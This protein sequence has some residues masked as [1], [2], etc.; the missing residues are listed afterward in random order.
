[1]KTLF[2]VESPSKISSISK[3][4]GNDYIVC[5]TVG[6]MLDLT[7]KTLSVDTDTMKTTQAVI[8]GKAKQIAA[9]RK[10]F[11]SCDEVLLAGD[12]DRE[13]EAICHQI[14]TVLKVPVTSTKR[15][16]FNEITKPALITAL[17]N[18][19]TIDINLYDAQQTRRII[20]R[21]VGYK[22][23]PIVSRG[24]GFK[25]LSAGRVQSVVLKFICDR[26]AQIDN[27]SP[28]CSPNITGTFNKII[29]ARLPAKHCKTFEQAA[30]LMDKAK[31]STFR[32]EDLT[33]KE[34]MR[35]PPAPFI[36]STMQQK[37]Q[38]MCGFGV[39]RTMQLAQKLYM[40]GKITYL[41]TDKPVISAGFVPK[42]QAYIKKTFGAAYVA[43][44][45]R[46]AKKSKGSQEAHEAIRPTKI[47]DLGA[48]ISDPMQRKLYQLIWRQA[49]ASCASPAK[50]KQHL[51]S[52]EVSEWPQGKLLEAKAETVLFPGFLAIFKSK[53]SELKWPEVTIG[54]E[55]ELTKLEAKEKF[56]DPPAAFT[57]ASMVHLL[58]KEGIG[59]PSTYASA[60][61]VVV[62]RGYVKKAAIEPQAKEIRV[63][64]LSAKRRLTKKSTLQQWGGQKG[65]LLPTDTGKLVNGFIQQHFADIFCK[66][67]TALMEKKLDLIA[68][69]ELKRVSV[70]KEFYAKLVA[71]LPAPP[72]AKPKK[73]SKPPMGT[74]DDGSEVHVITSRYGPCLKVVGTKK[75][76]A[77]FVGI[78]EG[79]ADSLTWDQAQFLCGYP[80]TICTHQ[81]KKVY[82]KTGRYGRYVE[83]NK[84]RVN[85]GKE[86]FKLPEKAD[87]IKML[88]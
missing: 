6:H 2:V 58:E 48:S 35:N 80:F 13:G 8:R 9:L 78:P 73:P 49:V 14:A 27:Y 28:K 83:W 82:L 19:T 33:S 29:E 81:K 10:A 74:L 87:I 57:G 61:S 36:T 53:D 85:V 4:I 65:R 77:K 24:L 79:T 18:P 22:V 38:Q 47:D 32:V 45:V 40:Q 20:D 16:M 3:Y 67:F 86:T 41:R 84:K 75:S 11:Q 62:D 46:T 31:P 12:P 5:A 72:K 59:R 43:K 39:K 44:K 30:E 23:S 71:Q 7:P 1:M 37:A 51:L 63:I 64:S 68:T 88:N 70:L 60:V 17:E 69:G 66:E 42:I 56:S 55:L 34:V 52:I 26:Q 54:Q 76:K 25:G 21:L 50:I 15:I